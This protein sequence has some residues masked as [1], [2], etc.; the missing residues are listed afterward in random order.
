MIDSPHLAPIER[1]TVSEEIVKRLVNLILD[2]ALKPGDKLPSERELM[3]QLAVGRSSLREAIK[4]LRALGVV[5]VRGGAGTFVAE[6]NI[7]A[8]TQPLSWRLLM[9]EHTAREVIEA[10]RCVEVEL[11]GLAAERATPEDIE[12]IGKKL[13]VMKVSSDEVEFLQSD[14]EFHLAVARAGNNRILYNVLETLRHLVFAWM[15]EAFQS[16]ETREHYRSGK[17]FEDHADIYEAICAH[18]VA[19]ARRVAAKRMDTATAFL[20]AALSST[21]ANDSRK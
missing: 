6:G 11:A 13:E 5:E 1:T 2:A 9:T 18:D 3:A 21:N 8:L 7:S 4:T 14:L 19:A 16:A 15:S 12:A 17:A 20:F 10:R